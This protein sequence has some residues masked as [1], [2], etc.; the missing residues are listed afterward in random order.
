[1]HRKKFDSVLRSVA[2]LFQVL[3]HPDRIRLLSLLQKEEMDVTHLHEILEMSQS[4]VSQHLKLLKMHG[5]VEE[6][7]EGKR[8]L[9]HIKIP[10]I[11]KVIT[12]AVELQTKEHKMEAEAF[13]L[14]KEMHGLLKDSVK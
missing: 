7:R 1:M 11:Q 8:A 5:L 12:A 6:R 4:S 10:E 14:L 3:S 9:Y 13:S 2:S